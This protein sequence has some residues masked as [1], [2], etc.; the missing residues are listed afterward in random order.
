MMMTMVIMKLKPTILSNIE[1]TNYV[2]SFS[3]LMR[4][5]MKPKFAVTPTYQ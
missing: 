5:M 4:R 2:D 3:A 1:P